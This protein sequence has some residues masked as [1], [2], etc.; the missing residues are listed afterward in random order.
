MQEIIVM[1]IFIIILLILFSNKSDS[2][3]Y[4]RNVQNTKT[5]KKKI[6]QID[7]EINNKIN[8]SE[9][10]YS[11]NVYKNEWGKH[12]GFFIIQLDSVLDLLKQKKIE[13]IGYNDLLVCF[14]WKFVRFKILLRDNFCCQD[15]GAIDNMHHVHHK[16]Y[17]KDLMP[18]EIDENALVTLCR[19]CHT[20]RHEIEIIKV[21]KKAENLFVSTSYQCVKCPRCNGTGYLPQYNHVEEGVCFLCHGNIINKT[22]FSD[23]LTKIK[24]NPV[25]YCME[26]MYDDFLDYI[27]SIPIDFYKN[28]VHNKFYSEAVSFFSGDYTSLF[29]AKVAEIKNKKEEL[30]DEDNYPF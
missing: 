17:L 20:R 2:I 21:Y 13:T 19:S 9:N 28:H 30:D 23:R 6:N 7:V 15:C 5:D 25:E 4:S 8:T 11:F 18:W 3:N 27:N 14:E 26:K 29:D 24:N 1:M 16:Y 10:D 12:E 22:I